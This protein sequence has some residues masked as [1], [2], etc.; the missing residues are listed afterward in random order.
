MVR[1][2]LATIQSI[3]NNN[4]W[5][6]HENLPHRLQLLI[7]STVTTKSYLPYQGGPDACVSDL[8]TIRLI[9]RSLQACDSASNASA[10]NDTSNIMVNTQYGF[11]I[12]EDDKKAL[13]K[14]TE[15]WRCLRIGEGHRRKS[16]R[17][18]I[19]STAILIQI[20]RS[21]AQ[22]IFRIISQVRLLV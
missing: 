10:S 12:C 9:M 20:V 3:S 21:L 18:F 11:F 16:S 7:R 6:D 15:S 2:Q 17:R 13:L 8:L 14:A 5:E 1:S 19:L 22:N 4:L